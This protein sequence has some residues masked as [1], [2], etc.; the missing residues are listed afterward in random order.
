MDSV[1]GNDSSLFSRPCSSCGLIGHSSLVCPHSSGDRQNG[2]SRI[3]RQGQGGTGSIK[4]PGL[5]VN[6]PVEVGADSGSVDGVGVDPKL[7]AGLNEAVE[8]EGNAEH[9]GEGGRGPI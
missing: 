5:A 4:H 6:Y 3:R 8:G 1:Y 9:E 7:V 2:R